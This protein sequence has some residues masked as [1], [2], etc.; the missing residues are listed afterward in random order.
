MDRLDK[1]LAFF[2]SRVG[3]SSHHD[4]K[5]VPRV[6]RKE[7]LQVAEQKIRSLVAGHPPREA[8]LVIG[9]ALITDMLGAATQGFDAVFVQGGIH[10]GEPFPA[11]FASQYGL[12]DWSPVAVVD[13]LG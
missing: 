11:D 2:I 7:A 10:A 1:R 9:D 13:S 8:V 12:S 4:L 3:L 6:D 5:R